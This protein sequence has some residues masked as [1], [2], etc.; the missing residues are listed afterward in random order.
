M[1]R[2]RR[3]SL[4]EL[5]ALQKSRPE[6]HDD[7]DGDTPGDAEPGPG[8]DLE[9]GPTPPEPG[10]NHNGSE[11]TEPLGS[12]TTTTDGSVGT[13]GTVAEVE[14]PV[15]PVNTPATDTNEESDP[16]QKC[17]DEPTCQNGSR[18]G[19]VQAREGV[20]AVSRPAE[21]PGGAPAVSRPSVTVTRPAE[22]LGGALALTRPSATLSQGERDCALAVSPGPHGPPFSQGDDLGLDE[23]R[24]PELA[25]IYLEIEALRHARRLRDDGRKE[26]REHQDRQERERRE[27]RARQIGAYLGID[28]DRPDPGGHD[29]AASG[30][31]GR[32]PPGGR[33]A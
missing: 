6:P 15:P 18:E 26:L 19:E 11:P 2:L 31:V 3:G 23:P 17:G 8:T 16:P 14:T 21:A 33:P 7:G 30:E 10:T 27:E 25:E 9:D 29:A 1:D 13:T 24:D 20:P 32:P 22:A 4:K 12:T 28:G 5:R